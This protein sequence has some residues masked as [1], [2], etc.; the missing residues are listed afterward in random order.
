MAYN[1]S[2]DVW[3][4]Y[5]NSNGLQWVILLAVYG[6]RALWATLGIMF[7]FGIVYITLKSKSL[8][9]SCNILIAMESAFALI[10]DLGY[11]V[12][13]LVVIAGTKFIRY[14]YCFWFLI[15]PCL[16]GDMAQMTM[17]FTGVDRLTC[18]MFPI[19]YKKRNAKCHLAFVWFVLLCYA[20]YDFVINY[21][22]YL[23]SKQL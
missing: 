1:A 22:D 21:I 6:F 2:T 23:N 5:F 3:F 11:Y 14:E 8:R 12:S 7:N 16:L 15:V 13:F 9:G 19:W 4:Q 18:V 20:T 10:L 17:V